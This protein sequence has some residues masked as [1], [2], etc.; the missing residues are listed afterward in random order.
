MYAAFQM[1]YNKNLCTYDFNGS[2]LYN[3]LGVHNIGFFGVMRYL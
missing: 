3:R 2:T 1:L